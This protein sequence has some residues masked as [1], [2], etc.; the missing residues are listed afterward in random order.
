MKRLLV[1]FFSTILT[2][3]VAVTTNAT[4]IFEDNF[5]SENGG[6][7]LLNYYDFDKWTVSGGSVDLIGVGPN[8]HG[9]PAMVYT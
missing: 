7:Y 3:S 1:I 5:N 6:N 9:S 4:V 2:L 8:G